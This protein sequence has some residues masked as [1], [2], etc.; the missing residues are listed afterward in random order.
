MHCV[1][2]VELIVS[3]SAMLHETAVVA[4]KCRWQQWNVF[5]SACEL[6]AGNGGTCLVL[7]VNRPLATEER[8]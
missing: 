6:P 3:M 1:S 7:H 8:V 2:I 4:N 5:S